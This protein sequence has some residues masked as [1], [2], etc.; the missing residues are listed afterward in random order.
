MGAGSADAELVVAARA[1]SAAAR[2]ALYRRY[3]NMVHGLTFRLAGR[4]ADH[5]DIADQVFLQAFGSL[6]QL[7]HAEALRPWLASHVVRGV[8][9][10]IR[11]RHALARLGF[12]VDAVPGFGAAL[13][14]VPAEVADE[15]E[16]LYQAVERLPMRLRMAF[17]L[18]RVENMD[19]SDIA[20]A[21]DA[22][23]AQV[24]RWIA[25][26]DA[27]LGFCADVRPAAHAT[28]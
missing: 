24:R 9:R 27:R 16:R 23:L 10:A 8:R 5:R 15:M 1:G 3:V 22:S 26:A 6:D 2:E 20:M 4:L 7:A 13:R 21:L 12:P 18:R 19:P 25:R 17:L 11:R 14:E 28:A